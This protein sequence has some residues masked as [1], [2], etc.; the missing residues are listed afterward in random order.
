MSDLEVGI[1]CDGQPH[2]AT[3]GRA[4]R[5]L[6]PGPQ[7]RLE[8]SAG[9]VVLHRDDD[10]VAVQGH[11]LGSADPGPLAGGQIVDQDL[12]GVREFVGVHAGLGSPLV[13][14]PRGVVGHG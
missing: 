12:P 3:E 6:Q 2:L 14:E 5:V 4:E 8:L 9:E 1:H 7:P 11:R 13:V 10:R